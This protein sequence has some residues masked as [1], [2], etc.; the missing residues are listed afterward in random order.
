[1]KYFLTIILFILLLLATVFIVLIV[2]GVIAKVI[3]SSKNKNK[4]ILYLNYDVDDIDNFDRLTYVGNH[5]K[6]VFSSLYEQ[7]KVG[8]TNFVISYRN[9]EDKTLLYK[10]NC[11]F[12]D[13][14]KIVT[15]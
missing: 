9:A 8:F 3:L 7:Y 15:H 4:G 11:T 6:H 1:M 12:E 10:L 14:L 13:I 5:I 2:F